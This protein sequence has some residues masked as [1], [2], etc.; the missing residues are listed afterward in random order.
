M[1]S[2]GDAQV[3]AWTSIGS[4]VDANAVF[5]FTPNRN[6]IM[7]TSTPIN[8]AKECFMGFSMWTNRSVSANIVIKNLYLK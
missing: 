3:R 2:G 8:I 4:H 6:D 5:A 7:I 1:A